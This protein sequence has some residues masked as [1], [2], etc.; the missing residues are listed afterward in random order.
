VIDF[1]FLSIFGTLLNPKI[2]LLNSL[3]FLDFIEKS[4]FSFIY[5][6][7]KKGGES[8][9]SFIFCFS[10][11]TVLAQSVPCVSK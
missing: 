5:K 7:R 11:S 8:V 1:P 6:G 9:F 10:W 3:L 4:I 2:V